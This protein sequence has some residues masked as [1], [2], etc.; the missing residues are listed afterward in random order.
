VQSKVESGY[1][2]VNGAQIYYESAGA[3]LPI[4]FIHA[5]VSDRRM[6]EP[7]IEVCARNSRVLRYDLRGFGKSAMP[8]GRYALR[9]DLFGLLKCLGID[10]AALVGCS[11]GGTTAI[12]FTLEHP[13]MV[14]ALVLIG[15]GVSGWNEWSE[16][17]VKLWTDL[18]ALVRDGDSER[19][20]ELN[21]RYW[22]DGPSRDVAKI[23]PEYR[24]LARQIH[25]ENFSLER[26]ARPGEELQPPAIGR[27]AE[28]RVPTMVVIGD[29][30]AQDLQ[31]LA[32][33]FA[34]EIPGARRTEIENA[35]HLP[36][37]EHP[38]EFNDILLDF[39]ES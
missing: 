2:A 6:W 29:S 30:D 32:W 7:Q 5:G 16:E 31:K 20:C 3:G 14:R 11:M 36:S 33:R 1:A 4:V 8:E 25:K 22:L 15:S 17:S 24:A 28:I 27:L 13:E 23:N 10:E 9:D 37:L 12:D 38:A 34:T 35:A 19:A 39:L 18:M 21:A 26:F